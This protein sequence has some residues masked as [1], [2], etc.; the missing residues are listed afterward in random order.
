MR[1]SAPEPLEAPYSYFNPLLELIL[2]IARDQP[3]LGRRLLRD[4]ASVLAR[5]A[6]RLTELDALEITQLG[7]LERIKLGQSRGDTS[8]NRR[9]VA[10][11][12]TP[13]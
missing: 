9:I 7:D 12:S 3:L 8:E 4:D 11:Q 6:P 2:D 1:L 13:Q 10:Q 5:I